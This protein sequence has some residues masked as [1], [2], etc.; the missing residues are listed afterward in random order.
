MV[1]TF[2]KK[3]GQIFW[4]EK[5]LEINFITDISSKEYLFYTF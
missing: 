1:Y 4:L 5:K 3:K 2:D